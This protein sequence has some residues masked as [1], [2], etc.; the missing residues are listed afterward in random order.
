MALSGELTLEEAM[1]LSQDT[2]RGNNTLY[3]CASHYN[4]KR[5]SRCLLQD[6]NEPSFR[7]E[8]QQKPGKPAKKHDDK[9]LR[10]RIKC[11]YYSHWTVLMD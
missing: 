6:T 8:N 2:L 10:I 4:N 11:R 1:G 5:D 7:L 9:P 3:N